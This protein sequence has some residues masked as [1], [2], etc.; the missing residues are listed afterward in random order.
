MRD[1]ITRCTKRIRRKTPAVESGDIDGITP[2]DF[3]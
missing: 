3:Q 2:R 1:S